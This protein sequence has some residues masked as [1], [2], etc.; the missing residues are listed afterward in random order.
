MTQKDLVRKDLVLDNK[1]TKHNNRTK[2]K[3]TINLIST[4]KK[5]EIAQCSTKKQNKKRTTHNAA[6]K[7][8]KNLVLAELSFHL[9]H[10]TELGIK[11]TWKNDFWEKNGFIFF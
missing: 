3:N 5:Q 11:P 9:K 4:G 8:H 10:G 7:I 2:N 6:H 1:K